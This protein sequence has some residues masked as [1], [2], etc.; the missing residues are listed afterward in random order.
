MSKFLLSPL[1]EAY[2]VQEYVTHRRGYVEVAS[3]VGM[4]PESLRRFLRDRGV[5][6]PRGRVFN[7]TDKWCSHCKRMLPLAVFG[8]K[9]GSA[10]GKQAYCKEC[11]KEVGNSSNRQHYARK[12]RYGLSREDYNAMMDGQEGKC[13]IC[14]QKK[15]LVVDHDHKTKMVRGLLCGGCNLALGHYNDDIGLVRNVIAYLRRFVLIPNESLTDLSFRKAQMGDAVDLLRWKNETDTRMNSIVTSD[16]IKLEDHLV[17]LEKTLSDPS[18]SLN[19]V[20]MDGRPIGDLRFNHVAQETE[21]SIR[22][23]KACR[24]KGVATAVIGRIFGRGI[25][26][27]KIVGHNLASMRVFIANGYMPEEFIQGPVNYYVFKKIA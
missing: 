22:L 25:L 9:T 18:V 19:I 7:A 12:R 1:E 2:V 21:V 16:E 17:W 5:I 24:G 26:T 15:R 10:S 6:R 20:E 23:E 13:A 14:R 3:E 27:A 8:D 4:P 11:A